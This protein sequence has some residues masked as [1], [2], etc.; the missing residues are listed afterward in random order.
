MNELKH[1]H[2]TLVKRVFGEL[3][4]GRSLL[5]YILPQD[6]VRSIDWETPV[7]LHHSEQ[8]WGRSTKFEDLYDVDAETLGLVKEHVPRFE[9]FLDD[10]SFQTDAELRGR[11]MTALGRLVLFCLRHSRSGKELVGQLGR[12]LG[13]VNEVMAAPDGMLALG[14]VWRYMWNVTTQDEREAVKQ[15]VR[16]LDDKVVS[17]QILSVA[18][19]L[20][21]EGE[22]KGERN[23]LEKL[24]RKKFKTLPPEVLGIL[25]K[26]TP[27]EIEAM[28]E[29][30]LTAQTLDEV[31]EG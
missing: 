28:G 14:A 20:W 11:A 12:W 3:E 31:L 17:G 23:L 2:D 15:M 13:L 6:V 10:F 19:M 4:H 9:F 24:L 25:E 29:R 27:R 30:I 26:A 8:G 22:Q 16:E 1:P 5:Q 21:E 18:E 7:V